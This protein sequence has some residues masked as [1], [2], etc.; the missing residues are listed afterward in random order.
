[1]KRSSVICIILLLSIF[2]LPD[3]WAQSFASD[4]SMTSSHFD[5]SGFP[6]WSKDLR[7]FEIVAF[8]SFPFTYFFSTVGFDTYRFA[9][10]NWDRRYAP[11]PIKPAAAIE[12]T[13]E[14]KFRVLGAAAGGALLVALIDY[15]I[16]VYKRNKREK[17]IRSIPAGTP[18][19][20]RTP[21]YEETSE[22]VSTDIIINSDTVSP[23]SFSAE[24]FSEEP[25]F[26]E[27]GNP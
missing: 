13:Q 23:E 24:N 8:G 1:M 21:L 6:Q 14:Q 10:N 15:S 9:T 7:R 18:I 16:V 3:L 22:S 11:W 4:S 12:Q 5:M 2:P 25:F 17:E 20:V 19:I 27:D 26:E